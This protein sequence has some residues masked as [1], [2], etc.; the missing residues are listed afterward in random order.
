MIRR[1]TGTLPGAGLVD[2]SVWV[3]FFSASPGKGRELRR[4]IADRKRRWKSGADCGNRQTDNR[5]SAV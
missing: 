1:T 4:M 2:S 3:D 5:S